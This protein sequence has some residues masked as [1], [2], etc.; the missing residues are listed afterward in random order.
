MGGKKNKGGKKDK[1][2]KTEI[3]EDAPRRPI[4]RPPAIELPS[5]PDASREGGENGTESTGAKIKQDS[6][7]NSS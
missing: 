2:G 7:K 3:R 4:S 5:L 1:G 6:P